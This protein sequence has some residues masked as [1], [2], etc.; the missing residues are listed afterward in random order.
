VLGGAAMLNELELRQEREHFVVMRNELIDSMEY[1]LNKQQIILL[2]YMIK[3][4][5]PDDA[6][7]K[8]YTMTIKAFCQIIGA[9]AGGSQYRNIKKT[10]WTIDNQVRWIEDN[11]SIIRVKWLDE[12]KIKKHTGMIEYSFHKSI[13]PY[14]FDLINSNE[15]HTRYMFEDAVVFETKYGVR[16]YEFIREHFNAGHKFVNINIEHIKKILGGSNYALFKDFR[17]NILDKAIEEVNTYSFINVKGEGKAR[18]GERAFSYV[19][20]ELDNV[21][22]D[23]YWVRDSARKE[24]LGEEQFPF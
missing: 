20:F 2:R 16:L 6:P 22:G 11:E 21:E 23:E 10:F 13:A 19:R 7:D 18:K 24:A 15:P 9:D 12:L 8:L 17:R 14:L 1:K 4:I 3:Q 5:Q